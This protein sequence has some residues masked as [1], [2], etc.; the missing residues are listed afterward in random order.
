ME[1]KSLLTK[2]CLSH[3]YLK[4]SSASIHVP[5]YFRIQFIVITNRILWSLGTAA[6]GFGAVVWKE[7]HP[8]CSSQQ[9]Q[10]PAQHRAGLQSAVLVNLNLNP[11][12]MPAA[13]SVWQTPV[14]NLPQRPLITWIYAWSSISSH[15]PGSYPGCEMGTEC[16]FFFEE[17]GTLGGG[18]NFKP[19]SCVK[20]DRCCGEGQFPQRPDK[21]AWK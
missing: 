13:N 4:S 8:S 20:E 3:I 9:E 14:M 12:G 11:L 1:E 19:S 6:R 2:T 16:I 15:H 17:R 10:Q 21:I 5:V 18:R 7:L